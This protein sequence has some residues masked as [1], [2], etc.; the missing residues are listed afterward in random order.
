MGRSSWRV[1]K[2]LRHYRGSLYCFK[3]IHI[4]IDSQDLQKFISI[5]KDISGLENLARLTNMEI[6]EDGLIKLDVVLRNSKPEITASV[7]VNLS[8]AS[9]TICYIDICKLGFAQKWL[10]DIVA[11]GTNIVGSVV[12]KD[13][14]SLLAQKYPDVISRVSISCMMVD[15]QALLHKKAHIPANLQFDDISIKHQCLSLKFN[16][17]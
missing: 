7:Q 9:D 14:I 12:D 15:L 2:F 16:L 11:S 6:T 8:L 1:D 17:S 4:Q 5:G 10:P 3:M 13:I